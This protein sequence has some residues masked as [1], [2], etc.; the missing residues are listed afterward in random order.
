MPKPKTGHRCPAYPCPEQVPARLLS[1]PKHWFMLPSVVRMDI[2]QTAKLNLL[3]P[4][5]RAALAAAQAIWKETAQ[6]G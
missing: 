5:R 3:H 6:N 1:C 2:E 4:D